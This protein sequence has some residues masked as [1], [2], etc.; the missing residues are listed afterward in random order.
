MS[1]EF[2]VGLLWAIIVSILIGIGGAAYGVRVRTEQ[3]RLAFNNGVCAYCGS[4][5]RFEAASG[6]GE[7]L[8]FT[9]EKCGNLVRLRFYVPEAKRRSE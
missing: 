3:E 5:L 7:T 6:W 9:C 4:K 8:F 1:E 2:S